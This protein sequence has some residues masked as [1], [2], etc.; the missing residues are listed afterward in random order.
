[1]N[2]PTIFD[3]KHKVTGPVQLW[4]VRREETERSAT[5][6]HTGR[7]DL[8]LTL[9][10]KL[11]ARQIEMASAERSSQNATPGSGR[12]QPALSSG[13]AAGDLELSGADAGLRKQRF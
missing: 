5:G 11:H 8:A 12:E 1:M 7:T 13:N 6:Q 4:L 10:K 3:A 9:E 2:S